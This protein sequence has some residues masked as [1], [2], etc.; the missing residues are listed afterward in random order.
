MRK[1]YNSIQLAI[2]SIFLIPY[3]V[4]AQL[5]RPDNYG[6]ATRPPQSLLVSVINWTLSVIAGISVLTI[7]IA[8][9]IYITS[10]GDQNRVDVAK[11]M[12]TY[13]V[14]GL[15]VALLG[16]VIV[17]SVGRALGAN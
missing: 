1:F 17:F 12:L 8:G 13:A 9:I 16:Y 2:L 15:I 7:V 10:A 6:L 4:H 14:I 3:T 11:K 5:Q